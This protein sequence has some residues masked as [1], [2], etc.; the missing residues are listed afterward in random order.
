MEQL[1]AITIPGSISG[2]QVID[3]LCGRIAAQL[4]RDCS[5]RQSDAY[6]GYR[7]KAIVTIELLDVYPATV[8]AEVAVG[9]PDPQ[10][11][12]TITLEPDVAGMADESGSLERP[13]DPAGITEA[14]APQRRM[15]V[16]RTRGRS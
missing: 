15:Y 16:S 4:A 5:L 2:P 9:N 10:R 13:I 11:S 14:P 7:A 12:H 3:D 1:Q 8:T 6:S